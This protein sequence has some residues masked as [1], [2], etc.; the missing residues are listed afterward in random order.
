MNAKQ[1]VLLVL[2]LCL[3]AFGLPFYF[4]QY[5]E[6]LPT[7]EEVFDGTQPSGLIIRL[8][9]ERDRST[10][11]GIFARHDT[12]A[13]F[14]ALFGIAIPGLLLTS[15]AFLW[16]GRKN[17]F[18]YRNSPA[19]GTDGNFMTSAADCKVRRL[20]LDLG[21][22]FQKLWKGQ[23]P[24]ARTFWG[25]Y[26]LGAIVCAVVAGFAEIPF[27]MLNVAPLGYIVANL[28]IFTYGFVATVGVWRSANALRPN[29]VWGTIAKVA[30]IIWTF[31]IFTHFANGGL[32][33]FMDRATA[34]H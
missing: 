10:T 30:V 14:A 26:V 29:Q 5:R 6:Q 31:A 9:G 11:N 13:N 4:L 15:A 18:K 16:L 23:Y 17:D 28:M 22:T 20:N 32:Q 34:S 33:E 25:F 8:D 19:G 2:V 1:R 27:A 21:N 24:L 7:A 12:G 3:F